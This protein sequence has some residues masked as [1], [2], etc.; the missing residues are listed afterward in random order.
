M[1][2]SIARKSRRH[3]TR[4]ASALPKDRFATAWSDYVDTHV[5]PEE[6]NNHIF[7]GTLPEAT[8]NDGRIWQ[9]LELNHGR[10]LWRAT[11]ADYRAHGWA[12]ADEG[13]LPGHATFVT[14]TLESTARSW[15]AKHRGTEPMDPFALVT[16][17]R[18]WR[19]LTTC[20][21]ATL[22]EED[23]DAELDEMIVNPLDAPL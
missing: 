23:L 12:T 6:L 14:T 5:D 16:G 11:D 20:G 22:D 21:I 8:D 13:D 10:T 4:A 2:A 9:L 19:W 18:Y 1:S 17:G 15:L 7:T 3:G